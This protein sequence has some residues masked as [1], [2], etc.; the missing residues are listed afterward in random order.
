ME[1]QHPS[2]SKQLYSIERED[3][4]KIKSTQAENKVHS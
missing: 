2:P 1:A 4:Y 3:I